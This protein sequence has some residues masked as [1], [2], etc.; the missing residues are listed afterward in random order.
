MATF[1]IGDSNAT[2]PSF[3][4]SNAATVLLLA[5]P[6]T[7]AGSITSITTKFSSPASNIKVGLFY[8]SGTSWTLRSAVTLGSVSSGIV[9]TSGLS[10]DAQVGDVLG[11]YGNMNIYTTNTGTGCK[12]YFGDAFGGGTQTY[13]DVGMYK[14]FT[15]YGNLIT[16]IKINGVSISKWNGVVITK[17]NGI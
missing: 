17:F 16:K 1:T 11:I 6:V 7:T 2:Y 14:T 5:N 15:F 3:T 4:P 10:L 12:Q 9:T 8:G 13:S